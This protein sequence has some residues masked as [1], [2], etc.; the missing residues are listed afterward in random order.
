MALRRSA[1]VDPPRGTIAENGA[2]RVRSRSAVKG[3]AM[4]LTTRFA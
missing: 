2:R 4:G 1:P 3:L